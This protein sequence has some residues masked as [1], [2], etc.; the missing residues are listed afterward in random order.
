[1]ARACGRTGHTHT[2]TGLGEREKGKERH[3]EKYQYG[4][5]ATAESH[6]HQNNVDY[7]CIPRSEGENLLGIRYSVNYS[8]STSA[9]PFFSLS[10]PHYI[11]PAEQRQLC[12]RCR[13]KDTWLLTE[14][15]SIISQAWPI[16]CSLDRITLWV[17]PKPPISRGQPVQ[18]HCRLHRLLVFLPMPLEAQSARPPKRNAGEPPFFLHFLE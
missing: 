14:I 16:T 18:V 5:T 6:G 8:A 2:L 17:Y 10:H 7:Q 3:K 4:Q 13:S 15:K 11:T 1:M 12:H 9:S